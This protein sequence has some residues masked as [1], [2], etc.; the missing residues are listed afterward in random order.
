MR[1]HITPLILDM[2]VL[3]F[4]LLLLPKPLGTNRHYSGGNST[5]TAKREKLG[6]QSGSHQGNGEANISNTK[7]KKEKKETNRLAKCVRQS[8][9][10]RRRRRREQGRQVQLKYNWN[11]KKRKNGWKND[12]RV[13]GRAKVAC[14]RKNELAEFDF[15]AEVLN[16]ENMIAVKECECQGKMMM[17]NYLNW[18]QQPSKKCK[19]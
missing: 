16:R 13:K 8:R 1:E 5:K 17:M 19:I 12:E 3:I 4:C 15:F 2:D 14:L 9:K 6:G 11:G 18:W 10:R 7:Y